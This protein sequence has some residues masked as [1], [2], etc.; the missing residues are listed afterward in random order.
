M[1]IGA[2]HIGE[3]V[4]VYINLVIEG[5]IGTGRTDDE[6]HREQRLGE[7]PPTKQQQ[8]RGGHAPHQQGL[9]QQKHHVHHA[10]DIEQLV[11]VQ[12]I[13]AVNPKRENRSGHKQIS[14]LRQAAFHHGLVYR[15]AG[16]GIQ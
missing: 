14:H 11:G 15:D 4:S 7:F 16:Q 1:H 2:H 10:V 12:P 8:Y 9:R 5:K 3:H 6:Q 13:S